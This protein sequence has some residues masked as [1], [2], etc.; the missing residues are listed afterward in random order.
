MISRFATGAEQPDCTTPLDIYTPVYAGTKVIGHE[1]GTHGCRVLIYADADPNPVGISEV[2]FL[3]WGKV[4]LNR[5]L[6]EGETITGRQ[7]AV[8]YSTFP[9]K[10]PKV[11]AVER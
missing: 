8:G 11:W 9:Q 10:S 3:G 2:S 1:N 6:K 4:I 7:D 5:A